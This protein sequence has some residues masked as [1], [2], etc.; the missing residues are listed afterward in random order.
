MTTA[1]LDLI[2]EA[3]DIRDGLRTD[4]QRERREARAIDAIST[5]LG[6]GVPVIPSCRLPVDFID[7]DFDGLS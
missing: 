4:A 2:E 7:Q 3:L 5:D 1:H 6:M